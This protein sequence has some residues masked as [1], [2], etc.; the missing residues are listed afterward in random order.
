MPR[1]SLITL[2]EPLQEN[3]VNKQAIRI[4]D[5]EPFS[6]Q[7]APSLLSGRLTTTTK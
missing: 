4:L 2:E 3:A 6:S 1:H 5:A 7:P